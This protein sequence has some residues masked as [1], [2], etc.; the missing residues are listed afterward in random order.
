MLYQLSFKMDKDLIRI[1]NKVSERNA[2][3]IAIGSLLETNNVFGLVTRDD[4]VFGSNGFRFDSEDSKEIWRMSVNEY[5]LFSIFYG[6]KETHFTYLL[7]HVDGKFVVYFTEDCALQAYSL[8]MYLN[9][10]YRI[11]D[12]DGIATGELT[13]L[14]GKTFDELPRNLQRLIRARVC[15]FKEIGIYSLED[16]DKDY[17]FEFLNLS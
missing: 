14:V 9:G 7:D 10:L 17:L 8:Y 4:I 5:Y 16:D 6:L 11:E 13:E 12:Y 1:S 3:N 15:S 2:Y